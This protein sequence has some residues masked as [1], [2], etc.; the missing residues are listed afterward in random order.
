VLVIEGYTVLW[1]IGGLSYSNEE[2]VTFTF[3]TN[4]EYLITVT[5]SNGQMS[6]VEEFTIVVN[7]PG[8]SLE[9]VANE[10]VNTRYTDVLGREC[11]TPKEGSVYIRS[12]YY[13]NGTV[14]REKIY[15]TK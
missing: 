6:I 5:V 9:E 4:G 2:N 11:I 10:L 14:L 13:Q 8:L 15:F 3:P 12:N 7:I 1:N